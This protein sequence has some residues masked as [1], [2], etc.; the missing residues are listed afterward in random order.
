MAYD[1]FGN[2]TGGYGEDSTDPYSQLE[3]ERKKREE[4]ERR[5][6]EEELARANERTVAPVAPEN[7]QN[8]TN[9]LPA[10]MKSANWTNIP[11]QMFDQRVGQAQQ[12]IND[13]GQ[14]FED[15]EAALRK[16]TDAAMGKAPEDT[17]A[18]K[19]EVTTYADGSKTRKVTEEIP[20]E[21]PVAPSVAPLPQPTARAAAQP[22]TAPIAPGGGRGYVNPPMANE[23]QPGTQ[24]A[25]NAS[26]AQ[27]ESG[28]RQDIGYHDKTKGSAYGPYGMTSAGYQEARRVNPNLPADITQATPEQ[29]TAA[30][31]AYTQQNAKYLTNYGVEPTANNLQA[32][33]FLGA[34]G[35]SDYLKT[36]YISPQAAAAN[37][38]EERVRQIVNQRLG[39]AQAQAS[40][41]IAQTQPTPEVTAPVS[42]EQAAPAVTG[43]VDYSLGKPAAAPSS[44]ALAINAYQA[45]QDNPMEL[46]KLRSDESQPEFIRKRAG[47]RAFELLNNER[48]V[49]VANEKIDTMVKNGDQNAIAKTLAAKPKTEEGSYLKAYLFARLGLNDLAKEEQIKLGAGDKWK[50]V[51]TA[52]GETGLIK[53]NA[54]GEPIQGT[55]SEGVDM[56]TK[57]LAKFAS[58]AGGKASDISMTPR[59]AVVDGELH[60]FSTKRTPQG[61]LYRDDTA[62]G[63]W[64]STAPQGLT[65]LGAQDPAHLKGLSAANSVVTKMSKANQDSIAAV[66]R[67]QFS[68]KQ[69]QSARNEAYANVTGKPMAAAGMAATAA[70]SVQTAA[71]ATPGPA[72]ATVGK[73]GKS[74]AQQILDYEAPPPVGPATGT[75]VAIMNE[76]NRLAAE[77]GKPFDAG[78]F[79]IA[80]KTRQDFTT[81]KQGQAVQSMNVAIDHLD[82]LQGAANALGNGRIP[83]FNDIAQRFAK[84]TGQP[85]PTDFNALKSIVGSEVAK[86]VTGGASALGDREEI[87]AEINRANSPAQLAGVIG[88]YQELMSGQVKGLQQTYES[89]GLKGFDDKLLPRTKFV[90]NKHKEPTRSNW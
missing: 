67:P 69:I 37:G 8:P 62:G 58:G 36:G 84:N 47:E 18:H 11:G 59:Q 73:G 33:H 5:R 4:D 61:I 70:P 63:A 50:P 17:V 46:M 6:R 12:R 14:M 39:G 13:V 68:Q 21:G 28:G 81:G 75:K 71:A 45:S 88:R 40:G 76:V 25:Y 19:Q 60:T 20:A 41:G 77:Q 7:P 15:P 26:I 48:Q 2:Y 38:G 29:Q 64:S 52:E 27:Q 1:A 79:K 43:A 72:T 53:Y 65:H 90:L 42:P 51:T 66:G 82:T 49:A 34:K 78:Q 9:Q 22:V 16:R 3:E 10:E 57:Q 86:A 74:I 54:R 55:T 30:Q 89:A 24:D 85:A 32:A 23:P 80:S 83:I 35:L 87:R 44:G 56:D 31:N